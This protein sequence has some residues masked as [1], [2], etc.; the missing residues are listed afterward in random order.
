MSRNRLNP[1]PS[2]A[3]LFAGLSVVAFA[4][5][6]IIALASVVL[7]DVEQTERDATRELASA[8]QD[9][10]KAFGQPIKAAPCEDRTNEECIEIPFRF[11]RNRSELSEDGRT[12]VGEACR[13][14]RMAVA[15]LLLKMQGQGKV[16]QQSNVVLVIE[17]H[18]DSTTPGE[19][20]GERARFLFNWR[21]SSERAA[22][23]LYEFRQCEVSP[24]K[25]YRI[26]S[27]G[28]ADT[29]QDCKKEPP[30]DA[31]HEQN[32]RTTMRIHV[33]LDAPLQSH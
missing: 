31:C 9:S 27:V 29:R 10:Y 23:V 12:Q 26:S 19:L 2:V 17:G 20:L 22:S 30:D 5:L 24:E 33:E 16:L 18:T 11:V 28:L 25:G 1:W 14:Y 8:F 32:R 21:L 6:I 13:I 15:Q 7:T 3:D 4:A